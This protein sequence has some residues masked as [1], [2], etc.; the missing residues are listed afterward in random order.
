MESGLE[1]ALFLVVIIL[2][3]GPVL[4]IAAF[5]RLSRL[6]PLIDQ[7]PRLTARIYDLEHKL[8]ALEKPATSGDAAALSAKPAA[9]PGPEPA[10][11]VWQR[12]DAPGQPALL[13]HLSEPAVTPVHPAPP[14]HV[15]TAH[16]T[17]S[18]PLTAPYSNSSRSR[19]EADVETMIAGHWFYYVGIL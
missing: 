16:S 7:I 1:F 4:A 15:A 5:V 9:A 12:P 11:G 13:G 17:P 10:H 3:V 14:L 18:L 6:T 8:A 19:S 2:I